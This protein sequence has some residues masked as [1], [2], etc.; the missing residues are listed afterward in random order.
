MKLRLKEPGFETYSGQMGVMDF[1]DGLTLKD[2]LTIDAV[3]LS[4]VMYVEWEDGTSP[5]VT[6]SLLDNTDTPAPIV[7]DGKSTE[8]PVAK[9]KTPATKKATITSYSEADL[10]KIA[11]K[12][13]IGGLRVIA[14]SLSV[15]GKSI[16]E[17]IDGILK[18]QEGK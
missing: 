18:A 13:G 1:E 7:G 17:L 10:G 8:E 12:D 11:D 5:S 2:V 15:K 9:V 14:E 3:K 16:K 4:C 6:Q